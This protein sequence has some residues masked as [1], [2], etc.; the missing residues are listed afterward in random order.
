M[1]KMFFILVAASCMQVVVAQKPNSKFGGVQ[2]GAITYSFRSMPDQS[3]EG[4]LK[5][6]VQSGISSI[7]L[8]GGAVEQY[9]GI[10]ADKDAARQWR[11]TVSMDKFK[12][13]KNMFDKQGVKIH[14]LKLGD[15]RWSDEENDYAF[16]VCK[17]LGAKGISLEVGE[18]AAK[19]MAPF[20]DKHKLYVI[21][22]NH[23]QPGKPDFSFDKM[24]SY[25]DRLMLN[26]DVGHYYRAT[27]QNPCD[28]IKRL[29]KR[30]VS[31]HLKDRTGPQAPKDN[32]NM[33]FGEGQ[34]P[35]TEIL[36]L[37]QKEKYAIN[38]DIELEYKV[39][40]GSDAVKEVIKCVDY[41]RK[42]LVK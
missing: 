14:I 10:P 9:A 19:R 17:T 18:E 6:A 37:I 40:E 25:G 23:E 41:C 39:P 7:E 20:A 36:Q 24:L 2:I 5:Y 31:L 1:K 21:M 34:T 22:H 32:S 35:L 27:G 16:R 3:L 42:A 29:N 12:E 30:I 26:F 4:M 33:P 11:T 13:I 8:M 28:L 38:C 15:H